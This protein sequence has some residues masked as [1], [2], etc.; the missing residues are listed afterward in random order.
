MPRKNG[1]ERL[2]SMAT[3][4]T[5]TPPYLRSAVLMAKPDQRCKRTIV[6][7]E[8]GVRRLPHNEN[9]RRHWGAV[10]GPSGW[11]FLIRQVMVV[12]AILQKATLETLSWL[13]AVTDQFL[14]K[15]SPSVLWV[16]PQLLGHNKIG[17]SIVGRQTPPPLIQVMHNPR[18]PKRA[19]GR[20][21]EATRILT[22][23]RERTTMMRNH[24]MVLTVMVLMEATSP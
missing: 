24:S 13:M 6:G 2:R 17:T 16:L 10:V 20:Q 3:T 11:P 18:R 23:T 9:H 15:Q 1:E 5:T 21:M 19:I 14:E 12:M 22:M 4:L 8:V 7:I